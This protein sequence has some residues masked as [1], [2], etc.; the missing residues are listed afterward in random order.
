MGFTHGTKNMILNAMTGRI[1]Y[2][3]IAP[4]CFIGVG[5]MDGDVFTEP[6]AT[7]GYARALIGNYQSSDSKCMGEPV[8]GNIKNTKIIDLPE[9]LSDWGTVTHFGLFNS[10]TATEP[11]FIGELTTPIEISAG[12]V[13]IFRVGTLSITI[14]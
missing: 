13:P 3:S 4:N 8:Q 10:M 11:F 14:V 5:I 7:A 1:N 6:E 12:Y 2:A 9:V